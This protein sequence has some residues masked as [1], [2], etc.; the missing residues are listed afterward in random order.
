MATGGWVGGQASSPV[1]D[2]GGVLWSISGV[3]LRCPPHPKSDSIRYGLNLLSADET[4][5]RG[6]STQPVI[7]RVSGGWGLLPSNLGVGGQRRS[8]SIWKRTCS[9]ISVETRGGCAKRSIPRP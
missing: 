8:E 7:L 9:F 4:Y 6:N 1:P 2:R 3:S 5:R